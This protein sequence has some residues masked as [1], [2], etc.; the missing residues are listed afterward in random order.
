MEKSTHPAFGQFQ[1]PLSPEWMVQIDGGHQSKG[2]H[3]GT[4]CP[5]FTVIAIGMG[6]FRDRASGRSTSDS[7]LVE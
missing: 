5:S 6:L 2:R 1:S 4:S 7:A 3:I